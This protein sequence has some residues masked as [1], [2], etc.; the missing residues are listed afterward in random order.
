MSPKPQEVAIDEST[1]VGIIAKAGRALAALSERGILTA[2]Q[3]ADEL[4]EPVST[5]YRLLRNLE[6]VDWVEKAE[7]RGAYRLG[8]GVARLGRDVEDSLDIRALAQERMRYLRDQCQESVHLCVPREHR[9]VCLDRLNGSQLQS[10]ELQ[11][12]GSTPMH[13][14]AAGQV[15]LAW[16]SDELRSGYFD[17]L[18]RGS[19]GE[20]FPSDRAS[21][22][23]R[24]AEIRRAGYASSR[25]EITPGV[26]VVASPVRNHRGSVIASLSVSALEVRVA[27]ESDLIDMVVAQ[28][29]ALS[30]DLGL[31]SG[32]TR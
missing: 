4:G 7:T 28:A 12:G 18:E 27:K 11:V 16:Q 6:A 32:L 5:V 25:G 21:L 31:T 24:L 23:A 29:Q 22:E 10:T 30:H 3:L 9:A 13:R 1:G 17:A 15:L 2:A 14:G 26:L 19:H 8:V 20:I